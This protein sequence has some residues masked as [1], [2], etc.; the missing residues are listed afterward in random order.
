MFTP[1][2]PQRQWSAAQSESR[3]TWILNHRRAPGRVAI[4]R[5]CRDD[6]NGGRGVESVS[7]LVSAPLALPQSALRNP[8]KSVLS[9][10]A[11]N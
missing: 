5:G 8:R 1:C 3:S 7:P 10:S 9:I 6:S 11:G 4:D 2:V